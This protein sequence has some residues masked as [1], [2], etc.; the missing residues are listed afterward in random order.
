MICPVCHMPQPGP[1]RFSCSPYLRE[2]ARKRPLVER[3]EAKRRKRMD[4][5]L[6]DSTALDGGP[7]QGAMLARLDAFLARYADACADSDK[8]AR[9]RE[10]YPPRRQRCMYS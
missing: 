1:H 10:P 7:T 8:A 2:Y 3:A 5:L 9:V 4:Y 6:K